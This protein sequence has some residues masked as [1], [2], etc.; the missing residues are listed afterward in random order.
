MN[1]KNG[2]PK[3]WYIRTEQYMTNP[4]YFTN[5]G[6]FIKDTTR[7]DKFISQRNLHNPNDFNEGNLPNLLQV[8]RPWA[9]SWFGPFDSVIEAKIFKAVMRNRVLKWMTENKKDGLF[10]NGC[11]ETLRGEHKKTEKWLDKKAEIYPE[12]FI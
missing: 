9:V 3:K 10:R 8:F 5:N 11:Y 12:F 7:F 2:K 4:L 1:L 6:D